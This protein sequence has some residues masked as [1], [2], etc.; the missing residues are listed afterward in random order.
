MSIDETGLPREVSDVHALRAARAETEALRGL[1]SALAGAHTI[2]EVS[3][4]VADTLA[5]T[6]GAAFSNVAVVGASGDE[7]RLFQPVTMDDGI[8]ARWVAVPIDR[9]TPLG[10]AIITGDVVHCANPVAI[11]SDFPAGASDAEQ[12]GIRA[13]AAFPLM[14]GERGPRAAIGLGWSEPTEPIDISVSAPVL[15]LC[16]AALQRAFT[17]DDATRLAALL[18]TLLQKAPVGFAF[19]D[20]ELRFSH[21]NELF[22]ATNG[23]NSAEQLG[24]HVRDV[25]PTL[26]DQFEDALRRTFETGE[27]QTNIE[28][29][30]EPAGQPGGPKIWEA[31][32]YPVQASGDEIIGAGVVTVDVTEQRH[33]S[34]MLRRLAQREREIAQRLQKGLLPTGVPDVAGYEIST[35]YEAGTAGLQVGGDWFEIVELHPNDLAIVVGDAV[36]HDLDAAIAMSQIRSALTGLGHSNDD[37]ASVIERLD[38]WANHN[39]SVLASTLF[40]GRLDPEAGSLRYTLAGHHPPL[41][42]HVDGTH[43]WFDADPGPPIGITSQRTTAECPL[44]IGDILVCYTDG[45]IENRT[46]PIEVGRRRLFETVEELGDTLSLAELTDSLLRRVPN[47]ERHDDIVVLTLRRLASRR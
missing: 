40:Y 28:I 1:A 7:L 33:Q 39:P 32:F 43:D 17:A 46:E 47:P 24:R 15:G 13:M 18:D 4:A 42:V 25:V 27:A 20:T 38:E 31:G 14:K 10:R 45:L 9:S 5:A 3:A 22:A 29:V 16:A 6:L 44:A 26:A 34:D 23:I 8:S 36:G 41:V 30:G 21:I 11:R 2:D 37:P 19:V 12:I 35:R